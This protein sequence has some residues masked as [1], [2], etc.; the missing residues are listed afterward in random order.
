MKA[1]GEHSGDLAIGWFV[2]ELKPAGKRNFFKNSAELYGKVSTLKIQIMANCSQN[3]LKDMIFLAYDKNGVVLLRKENSNPYPVVP[4]SI[5][6]TI[7]DVLCSIED[8]NQQTSKT[9]Y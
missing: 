6:R 4:G 8:Q 5:G 3:M 1:S 9:Y 2:Y 7:H